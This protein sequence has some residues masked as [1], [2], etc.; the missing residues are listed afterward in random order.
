MKFKIRKCVNCECYTL[1]DACPVCGN[2]TKNP[3]PAR[4]SPGDPYG[5]YRRL[6]KKQ[7]RK[8]ECIINE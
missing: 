3:Q 2:Q 6:I 8:E 4:F 5:K 7:T 1:K